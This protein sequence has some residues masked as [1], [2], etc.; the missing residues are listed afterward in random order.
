MLLTTRKEGTSMLR[1]LAHTRSP[2]LFRFTGALVLTLC[3]ACSGGSSAGAG[4]G[5]ASGGS[6]AQTTNSGGAGTSAGGANGSGGGTH[7]GGALAGAGESASDAG[8]GN[9]G[10]SASPGGSTNG[11][12]A[13]GGTNSGGGVNAGGAGSGCTFNDSFDGASLSDCWTVLNGT[14]QAPLITTTVSGGALHLS[15]HG[16]LNGV[17][18]QGSTKSLVYKLVSEASFKVT[19]TMHPRKATNAALL[20][21]KDLHV[22]GLMLRDPASHGGAS[23]NY[24]LFM[25]GHSENN[26]GVVHQG[27]EFKST[28]NGCSDWNE[29]DWDAGATEQDAELRICRLG[30]AFHLYKRVPGAT[31]WAAAMPP[32]GCPGNAVQSNVL[33]RSD[34]PATV[35]VGLGLNFSSPSDLDVAIDAI[36]LVP[37]PA[38]ATA[39]DCESD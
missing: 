23:E 31:A 30:A 4:G 22:G 28:I 35:Q 1:L 19:A 2:E 5:T 8:T 13:S 3:G 27:V 25:A 16:D 29:P 12:S 15:A 20:P 18:Y 17:W 33:T 39:T 14:P 7:E 11:G 34:L 24:L 26:N 6:A 38:N 32:S 9:S 10:G 37:L 21:T 36:T